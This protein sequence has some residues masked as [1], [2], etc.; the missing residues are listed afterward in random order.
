MR[1]LIKSELATAG[2]LDGGAD[3]P[4][5]LFD[6]GT[7][8]VLRLE[9]LDLGG[10]VVAH[11]IEYG[12][13]LAMAAVQHLPVGFI[14][15]MDAGFRRGQLEDQPTASGVDGRELENVAKEGA[16]GLG[17]VAVEKDVSADQH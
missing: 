10:Q 11:E 9:Q 12:S 7:A 3:P 1:R 5:L 2:Q 14:V 15:R 8:D 6:L 17:I 13:Q 16:I 4:L